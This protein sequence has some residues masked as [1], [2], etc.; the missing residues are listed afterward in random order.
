[1]TVFNK[2][3][4]SKSD[5]TRLIKD[6]ALELGYALVGI[7]SAEPF[8]GYRE[9]VESRPGSEWLVQADKM[10][11]QGADPRDV[12]SSAKSIICL[13]EDYSKKSYPEKLVKSF[14]R[15]YL[16]RCYVPKPESINGLRRAQFVQF[17][18]DL[19]IGVDESGLLR[20]PERYA[21]ARAGVVTYGGNNFAYAE[22]C[23]SFVIVIG[24]IVDVELDYDEPT[25]KRPCPPDCN[26]CVE[27]CPTGA[28]YE[29]GKLNTHKCMLMMEIGPQPI[30]E[31]MRPKLGTSIHGCDLCQEACPRNKKV[32]ENPPL[33]D[34]FLERL[35][36]EFD[37]EKVL[38]LDDGYY[39]R[40][41]YPIAYNYIPYEARWM[42]QRNAA[43]ALGNS[44][45]P[46]HLPALRRAREECPDEV[47]EYVDWAI[48][49]LEEQE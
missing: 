12:M 26:R 14:G 21:A 4:L 36:E 43:I 44:G 22:G 2:D 10:P 27:A 40:V 34:P 5:L 33:K 30:P 45:D 37:L 41:I 48:V 3:S 25:V 35:A 38:L 6:K 19:G 16:A 49:Q 29:K 42:F 9:E 8:E 39:E 32:L 46:S 18:K 15:C 31:E 11:Y 28:L 23:G 47:L 17:L 20:I 1:M 24:I 13:V 7:T